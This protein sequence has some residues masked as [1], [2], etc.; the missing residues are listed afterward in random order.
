MSWKKNNPA[1]LNMDEPKLSEQEKT[2]TVK[3]E[4]EM[5]PGEA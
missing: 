2:E 1:Q 5:F 4:S 3:D